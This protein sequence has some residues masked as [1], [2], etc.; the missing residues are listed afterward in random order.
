MTDTTAAVSASIKTDEDVLRLKRR[1]HK[2]LQK[3]EEP[4]RRR[5]LADIAAAVSAE[6]NGS[7]GTTS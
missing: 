7:P 2:L 1:I 3:A 5:V 6:G 4:V